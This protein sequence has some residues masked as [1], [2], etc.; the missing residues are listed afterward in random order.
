MKITE[1]I[2]REIVAMLVVVQ[3]LIV[4]RIIPA[5]NNIMGKK[6]IKCAINLQ[7]QNDLDKKNQDIEVSTEITFISNSNKM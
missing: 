2:R 4:R 5:T 1:N 7:V 3:N 6:K